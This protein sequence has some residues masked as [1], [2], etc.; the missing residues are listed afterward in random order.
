[1][2]RNI[3][4]FEIAVTKIEAKFKLSQNRSREEQENIIGSLSAAA[5]TTVSDVSQLMQE[6]CLG[7]TARRENEDKAGKK[8]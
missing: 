3:I 7:I 5:D 4:G 2:L 6:Q 1:M 8:K